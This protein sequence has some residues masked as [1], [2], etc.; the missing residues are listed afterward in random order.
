L[1]LGARGWDVAALQFALAWHGFP[2]GALDGYLGAHTDAALRRFQAWAGIT[3]DD[4]AGPRTVA[5]LRA[6]RPAHRSPSAAPSR[7]RRAI[8]SARAAPGSMRASTFRLRSERRSRRR[9]GARRVRRPGRWRLGHD[10]RHRSRARRPHAVRAPVPY[11][12][13]R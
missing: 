8:S 4:T 2:S 10:G 1:A 6:P 5:A 11:R 3:P 13:A 7:G 9:G 12:R